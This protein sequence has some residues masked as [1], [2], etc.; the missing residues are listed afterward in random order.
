MS[1]NTTNPNIDSTIDNDEEQPS[2]TL[3]PHFDVMGPELHLTEVQS[4]LGTDDDGNHLMVA[5][6]TVKGL[7]SIVRTLVSNIM[8]SPFAL[9]LL[10]DPEYS[11]Y[12]AAASEGRLG[13]ADEEEEE[14]TQKPKRGPGR[15]RKNAEAPVQSMAGLGDGEALEEPVKRGPGRPRK[16]PLPATDTQ[17]AAAPI[18]PQVAAPVVQPPA[19]PQEP[20]S[21]Q[22]SLF[23]DEPEAPAA[24]PAVNTALGF[25]PPKDILDKTRVGDVI[26]YLAQDAHA[27]GISMEQAVPQVR[28]WFMDNFARTAAL[29]SSSAEQ[30]SAMMDKGLRNFVESNWPKA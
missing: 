18:A 27:K 6:I 28:Q 15:P 21:V 24:A 12:A 20:V 17:P 14:E 9:L 23:D 1:E 2:M 4:T 30:V 29:R 10:S 3:P 16:H 19:P 7:P 26:R 5:N 8:A 22:T 25:N 11:I 13:I